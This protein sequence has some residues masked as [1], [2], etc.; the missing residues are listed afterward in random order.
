M[1]P[2]IAVTFC[3]NASKPRGFCLLNK[4]VAPPD[5][6]V[7]ALSVLAGCIKTDIMIKT[8]TINNN[9]KSILYNLLYLLYQMCSDALKTYLRKKYRAS[10]PKLIYYFRP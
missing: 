7:D 4:S 8:E 10:F 5:S 1:T 9:V 6:A 3:I 2:R